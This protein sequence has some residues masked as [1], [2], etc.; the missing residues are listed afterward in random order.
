MTCANLICCLCLLFVIAAT[1]LFLMLLSC[2]HCCCCGKPKYQGSRVQPLESI[3][4]GERKRDLSAESKACHTLY[5]F[6]LLHHHHDGSSWIKATEKGDIFF[7][8]HWF[9]W[10]DQVSVNMGTRG[11]M[12]LRFGT[13]PVLSDKLHQHPWTGR[14]QNPHRSAEWH[15]SWKSITEQDNKAMCGSVWAWKDSIKAFLCSSL[16]DTDVVLLQFFCAQSTF[17]HCT[18][19]VRNIE[20]LHFSINW[21]LMSK[22]ANFC[23][24]EKDGAPSAG[25][26]R[27][28]LFYFLYKLCHKKGKPELLIV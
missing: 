20:R 22:G 26:L 6:G 1:V 9:A 13:F 16:T 10:T 18:V 12:R 25:F 17:I 15:A 24:H 3:W 11:T 7:E 2:F 21:K 28:F 27:V 14:R 19:T 8:C 23:I 5:P 4:S